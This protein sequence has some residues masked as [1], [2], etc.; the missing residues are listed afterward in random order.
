MIELPT[1]PM[2]TDHGRLHGNARD[3]KKPRKYLILLIVDR[4][5]KQ[6]ILI[7][8]RKNCTA[9]EIFHIFWIVAVFGIPEIM[10]SG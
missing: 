1:R 2:A 10:I 8:T 5:L 4:F 9:E 7:L 3:W 6:T